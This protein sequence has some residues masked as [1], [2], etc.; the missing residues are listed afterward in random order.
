MRPEWRVCLFRDVV[1]EVKRV[2]HEGFMVHDRKGESLKIKSPY[3]L[4]KKFLS[5]TGAQ[6]LST[7]WLE[8]NKFQWDEEFYPLIDHIKQ[9]NVEFSKL[10]QEG[11]KAFIEE[12]LNR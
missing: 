6:R 5:R 4:V 10:D 7:G 12:F 8:E 3:Y 1:A 2:R 11:R 9:H